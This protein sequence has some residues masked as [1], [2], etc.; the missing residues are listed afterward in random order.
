MRHKPTAD[1]VIAATRAW[2]ETVVV[3]HN[4]CPFA[5]REVEGDSVRYQ[6][7]TEFD[8]AACLQVLMAECGLLDREESVETTLMVFPVGFGDFDRFL[9]LVA[10]ADELLHAQGYEGI[11]QLANFH[12]E[13]RF[14]G[15]AQEEAG[16]Y[17]NRSPYP[18]LHLIREASIERALAAMKVVG[19]D[20]ESIPARNI[21]LAEELGVARLQAALAACRKLAE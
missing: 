19:Q 16:N 11:Y 12:P 20:P 13:Y 9:D 4:F 21:A 17:T 7:V 2:V 1:G 6:V 15:A 10:L 8:M 14:E 18:I 3:G 5:R